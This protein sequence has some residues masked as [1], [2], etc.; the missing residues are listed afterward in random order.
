MPNE[1]EDQSPPVELN[2]YAEA[3]AFLR[4]YPASDRAAVLQRLGTSEAELDALR[5][6]RPVGLARLVVAKLPAGASSEIGEDDIL[7]LSRMI[8]MWSSKDPKRNFSIA[9]L[10]LSLRNTPYHASLRAFWVVYAPRGALAEVMWET[11]ARDKSLTTMQADMVTRANAYAPPNRPALD[12]GERENPKKQRT[13]LSTA[14][15]LLPMAVV[16]HDSRGLVQQIW[17]NHL[18]PVGQGTPPKIIRELFISTGCPSIAFLMKKSQELQKAFKADVAARGKRA[19]ELGKQ[20]A[21][22]ANSGNQELF[23]SLKQELMTIHDKPFDG[24][25]DLQEM[26]KDPFADKFVSKLTPYREDPLATFTHESLSEPASFAL[27]S[28]LT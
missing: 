17:R 5:R 9:R 8:P 1:S 22:A 12:A 27:P 10:L 18:A 2:R 25:A 23:E 15:D 26:A 11:G 7:F 3:L 21:K 19:G 16:S 4:E 13:R 28:L 14:L 6:A 24:Q 20:M